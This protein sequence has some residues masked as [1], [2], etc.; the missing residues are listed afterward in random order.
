M[1][2]NPGR[3]AII[4]AAICLALGMTSCGGKKNLAFL[5]SGQLFHDGKDLYDRGK[6]L[7]S[8]EYFQTI[9]YNYPGVTLV[10]TAQYYLAMSYFNNKDYELSKVEFNRLAVNYPSSAFFQDALFMKAVAA[11]ESTPK[12]YGLDQSELHDAISELEDFLVDFPE[13]GHVEEAKHYLNL[14][15]GRLAHKYYE[16]GMVYMNIGAYEA[17]TIYFQKV[18]DD[19]TNTDFAPEAMF[20]Y[21]MA[22]FKQK[23]YDEASQ[24]FANFPVAF[25]KS[26][27][28]AEAQQ[29]EQESAFR[30]ARQAYDKQDFAAA[31]EKLLLFKQSY[32]DSKFNDD[33]DKY[34][35]LLENVDVGSAEKADAGS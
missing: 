22:R 24:K 28:V 12:H 6:Y 30:A 21:A 20:K 29:Y 33:V 1:K 25:P 19:Y 26:V 14:A 31:K 2:I 32:P 11:F 17:A 4:V 10:D 18:I 34:L 3:T 23:K 5:D 9:V 8:I 7:K 27:H 16:D 35:R 15:K 13:S